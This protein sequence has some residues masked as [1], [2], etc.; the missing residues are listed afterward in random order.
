MQ[1]STSLGLEAIKKLGRIPQV[2]QCIE[3]LLELSIILCETPL[4]SSCTEER[5]YFAALERGLFESLTA[6]LALKKSFRYN[7]GTIQFKDVEYI[8]QCFIIED[9]ADILIS[10]SQLCDIAAARDYLQGVID[11]KERL[12]KERLERLDRLDDLRREAD[13]FGGRA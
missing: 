7:P 8:S 11:Y 3:D 6:C 1:V 9:I 13:D 12:L 2:L 5:A 4:S 10:T